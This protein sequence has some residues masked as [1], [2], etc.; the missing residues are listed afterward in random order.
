MPERVAVR[1]VLFDYGGVVRREDEFEF[2]AFAA[3]HGLAP[4]ALWK[5]FHDIPEYEP[6]RTGRLDDRR[7]RTG[8]LRAIAA[9]IGE[10]RGEALLREWEALQSGQALVEPEMAEV[11]ATLRGRVRL[12]LLSNAGAGGTARLE[13]AGVADL[14]DDDVCSG[15]VG[16]AKPDPEVYRLAATR[17][18]VEPGEC[19]F[20]DD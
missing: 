7:Y 17:L 1:A 18:G 11:L 5:A 15:D 20:V 2:D 9:H 6:S 14:F 16:L 3:R 12:G 10:E 19:L 8:V 13:E 4:G